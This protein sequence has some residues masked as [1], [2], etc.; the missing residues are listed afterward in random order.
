MT[1]NEIADA[2][3]ESRIRIM[4]ADPNCYAGYATDAAIRAVA[5][6]EG[7]GWRE[8]LKAYRN[9]Y[10]ASK[11]NRDWSLLPKGRQPTPEAKAMA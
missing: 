3:R 6:R 2:V 4:T 7:I 5:K 1:P 11:T 9:K 8:V 10:P